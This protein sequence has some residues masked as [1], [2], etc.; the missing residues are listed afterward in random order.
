MS[1]LS[2]VE[3]LSKLG[4]LLL[5]ITP[6]VCLS[7]VPIFEHLHESILLASNLP[8]DLGLEVKKLA[9]VDLLPLGISLAVFLII[10]EA[11]SIINS[12]RVSGE[13][14]DSFVLTANDQIIVLVMGDTPNSLWQLDGLLALGAT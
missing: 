8:L 7:R 9:H 14:I 6:T 10:L 11:L 3:Y 2:R 4:P 13:D 5:S 12:F 1:S